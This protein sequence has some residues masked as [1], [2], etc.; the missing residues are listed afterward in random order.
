LPPAETAIESLRTA[1]SDASKTRIFGGFEF[2]GGDEAL[3]SDI[4]QQ[5]F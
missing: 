3:A 2:F 1:F 4:T 5:V